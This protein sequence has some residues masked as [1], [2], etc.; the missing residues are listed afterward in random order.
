MCRWRRSG[1]SMSVV[2]VRQ[3][4]TGVLLAVLAIHFPFTS[5]ISPLSAFLV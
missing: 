2:S 1:S 4:S 3:A 5:L